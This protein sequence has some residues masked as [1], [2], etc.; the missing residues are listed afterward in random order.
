MH[1]HPKVQQYTKKVKIKNLKALRT[2]IID[3]GELKLENR[4]PTIQQSSIKYH[5]TQS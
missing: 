2:L 1:P 3:S 4:S 5:K